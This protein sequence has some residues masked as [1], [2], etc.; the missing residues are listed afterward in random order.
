MTAGG[1]SCGNSGDTPIGVVGD[2]HWETVSIPI[3]Q[4]VAPPHAV[5]IAG[6]E[7]HGVD[8]ELAEMADVALMIPM[9]AAV[10]SLGVAVASALLMYSL[11]PPVHERG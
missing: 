2:G 6:N 1:T 10:D 3:S 11:K 5:L 9:A 8:P 7:G 4:L